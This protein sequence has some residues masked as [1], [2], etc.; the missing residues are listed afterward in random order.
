MHFK[1]VRDEEL[2]HR[3]QNSMLEAMAIFVFTIALGI[4][5]AI[6]ILKKNQD[7][8][9]S[10]PNDLTRA[11]LL[12]HLH[13]GVLGWLSLSSVTI[14]VWYFVAERDLDEVTLRKAHFVLKYVQIVLPTYVFLFYFTFTAANGEKLFRF[15]PLGN[16]G[17][18]WYILMMLGALAA[19][20]GFAQAASFGYSQLPKL[21]VKTTPHYLFLGGMI[22][23]TYGGFFGFVLETQHF[24]AQTFFNADKGQDGV[25]SHAGAMEAGYLFMMVAG[26]IEWQILGDKQVAMDR[27]GK[28]EV[29]SFFFAGLAVS[30]GGGFNIIPIAALNLPLELLG[31]YLLLTRVLMKI[32][33]KSIMK[34][35]ADRFL[36]PIS[37]CLTFSIATFIYLLTKIVFLGQ[38][39][40]EIFNSPFFNGI[41]LANNHSL[42][43]G[44]MTAAVFMCMFAMFKEA[45]DVGKM[46]E[47]VGFILMYIGLLGFMIVLIV[48]GY[49]QEHNKTGLAD[50]RTDIAALMGIGLYI[51]MGVILMRYRKVRTAT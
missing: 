3:I 42:F 8:G 47:N 16:G 46:A 22:T 15:I 4:I 20:G 43:V 27:S 50:L 25:A 10:T 14:L 31:Y 41:F 32:D 40:T 39:P 19:I 33:P 34:S 17:N 7:V 44:G 1:A 38:D 13:S 6:D 23:S 5:N 37:I 11:E 18:G 9:T 26:I 48:R 49:G 28:I 45:S 24:L 36:L 51:I 12:F 35:G 2:W 29:Y 21:E 30:L